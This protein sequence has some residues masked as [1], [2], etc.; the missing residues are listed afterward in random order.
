MWISR[1]DA[2]WSLAAIPV[3]FALGIVG[4][5]TPWPVL[6]FALGVL[7]WIVIVSLLYHRRG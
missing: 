6:V 1:R 2:A 3:A 4:F 5:A 7:C